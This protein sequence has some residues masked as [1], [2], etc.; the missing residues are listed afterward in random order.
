[1]L[2]NLILQNGS[3]L[4][5][6]NWNV[7]TLKYI[8]YSEGDFRRLPNLCSVQQDFKNTLHAEI[9]VNVS[10]SVKSLTFIPL[11]IYLLFNICYGFLTY[12]GN[13]NHALLI[14]T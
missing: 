5:L 4:L 8:W 7:F 1:M 11:T 2:D 9:Y 12:R 3:N 6:A 10:N 13:Y 14:L